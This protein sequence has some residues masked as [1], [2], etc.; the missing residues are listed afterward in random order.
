MQSD[1]GAN[2]NEHLFTI[3]REALGAKRARQ[4]STRKLLEGLG[5]RNGPAEVGTVADVAVETATPSPPS[6]AAPASLPTESFLYDFFIS[7]ASEDKVTVGRPLYEALTSK[8][9]EVWFD[10]A[11]LHIG[12]SLLDKIDEGLA[13]CRFGIV[14]LS[15]RFFEKEWTQEELKGLR[16]RQLSGGP[17]IILPVWKDVDA[18]FLNAIHPSLAQIKAANF[19]DGIEKVVAEI[20]HVFQR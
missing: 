19:A 3:A 6:V 11:E 14:I 10:E 1:V 9:Y 8:S 13:N 16:A 20:E 2:F 17:G 5:F 18:N 4:T 12:D 7:H 15:P